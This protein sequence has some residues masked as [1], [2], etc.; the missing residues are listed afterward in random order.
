MTSSS[1]DAVTSPEPATGLPKLLFGAG[2][3]MLLLEFALPANGLIGLPITFFLKNRLQLSAQDVAA[4]NLW[5]SIPLYLSFLFG[6]LRD[7]WSPFG[8][9]DRGHLITFGLVAAGMFAGL[10]FAPPTYGVLLIGVTLVGSGVLM[11]ASAAR[12]MTSA[13]GQANALS[14]LAGVIVNLAN[15]TPAI[16]AF[17]LGGLFSQALGGA[18]AA[19]AARAL[20]LVGGGLMLMVAAFGVLGPRRLLDL[21]RETPREQAGLL[22]DIRRLAGH[23]PIYPALTIYGLWQFSPALGTAMTYYLSNTLHANDAQVGQWFALFFAGVIPAV[24]AYG[25]LCRRFTLRVLLWAGTLLGVPQ[26]MPFLLAQDIQQALFAAVALGMLGGLAQAAYVDLAIRSCPRGLQ[27]TMMMFLV[28]MYWV[29]VRFSDLWGT[30]L[31]DKQGGFI[32]AVI[33]TTAVYALILPVLLLVPRHLT[34]TTD[35]GV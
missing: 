23:W 27:G 18:S 20:F 31:Y 26:F 17:L 32:T 3:V 24:A 1:P 21:Q 35:G 8:A 5:A 34:A 10:A 30:Y 9:G 28:T 12:G 7:R 13:I 33:A 6:L 29:P 19:N 11:A 14:G 25:W 4:F 22:T 16:V 2:F 15:L